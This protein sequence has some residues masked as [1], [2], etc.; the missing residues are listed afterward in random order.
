MRA[1]ATDHSIKSAD[2]SLS[3]S[4]RLIRGITE[5]HLANS[6]RLLFQPDQRVSDSLTRLLES[7]ATKDGLSRYG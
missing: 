5:E 4:L 6:G 3:K 7:A 2:E 1:S